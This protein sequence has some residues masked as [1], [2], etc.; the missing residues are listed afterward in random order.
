MARARNIKPSFFSNDELA[1]LDPL[2]RLLFIGMW[3]IADFKGCFE[4]K[5]KRVK[6]Q[7]LPYDN[8]DIEK[9]TI[10]LDKSGFISIYSVL[11]QLYVKVL[12]FDKHQNPHKNER[13]KGSDIPDITEADFF[14]CANLSNNNGLQNIENNPDKNGTNPDKNGSDPADS[15]NLIPSTLI[16]DPFNTDT[17]SSDKPKKSKNVLRTLPDDFEISDRVKSWAEKEGH[18][19]LELHLERFKETAIMKRYKYADWDLAFMKAIREDWGKVN[20]KPVY[21]NNGYQTQAQRTAAEQEK[22]RLACEPERPNEINVTP[23][24]N[25]SGFLN[26]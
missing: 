16:P 24:D 22:W 8:C 11:D 23:M 12:N 18:K 26:E 14:Y 6:V 21:Q 2:A 17:Q 9:L 5:P 19:N 25:W 4:Y 20:P 7:L 13:D 1:E 10:N 3:T 15:L